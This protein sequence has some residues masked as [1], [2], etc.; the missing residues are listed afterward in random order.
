MAKMTLGELI[1]LLSK[2]SPD[3]LIDK[4]ISNRMARALLLLMIFFI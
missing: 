3:T 2:F 1:R 4:D